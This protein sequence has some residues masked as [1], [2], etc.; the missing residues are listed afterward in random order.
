MERA[1]GMSDN[2]EARI[3]EISRRLEQVPEPCAI[4]MGLSKSIVDMGLIESIELGADGEVTIT[5]C[6]T[7][8]GCVHF[9]SMQK[10]IADVLESLEGLRKINVKQTLDTLWTPDREKA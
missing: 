5:M 1:E 10:Y 9:N 8:A 6:L 3:A 4:A 7:D 2:C